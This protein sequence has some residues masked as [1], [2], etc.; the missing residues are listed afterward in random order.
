MYAQTEM[1]AAWRLFV[2][3]HT[4]FFSRG[5]ID[6]YILLYIVDEMN[7]NNKKHEWI[8]GCGSIRVCCNTKQIYCTSHTI[9]RANRIFEL[10][11]FYS[12][13]SIYM[14]VNG[15]KRW[16]CWWWWWWSWWL[17]WA[18]RNETKTT[19]ATTRKWVYVCYAC[20]TAQLPYYY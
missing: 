16:C 10:N 20:R 18:Q 5:T 1:R 12:Y 13:I 11:L 7:N 8:S 2:F 19:T 3:T 15:T 6:G 14:S 4:F 9:F 17:Y